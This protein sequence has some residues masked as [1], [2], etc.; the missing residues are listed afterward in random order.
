MGGR[1]DQGEAVQGIVAKKKKKEKIFYLAKK[2]II[3]G[4]ARLQ[5]EAHL[6]LGPL[7]QDGGGASGKTIS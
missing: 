5:G 6:P 4:Y 3:K 2:H 7:L 1:C